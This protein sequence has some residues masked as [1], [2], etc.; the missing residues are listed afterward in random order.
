MTNSQSGMENSRFG[1][2]CRRSRYH[3]SDN[4]AA[5]STPPVIPISIR[6]HREA[7]DRAAEL[8]L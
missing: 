8:Q 7:E 6:L 5:E 2:R 4:C 3:H 1:L